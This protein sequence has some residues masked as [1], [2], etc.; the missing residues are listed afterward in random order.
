[1][2]IYELLTNEIRAVPT[3]TF[4]QA[5]VLE[6]QHLQRVLKDKIDIVAPGVMVLTEE[7]SEWQD[8]KRRIDLLALDSQAN[9]VVI[10][11]KRDED[12]GHMDLQALRYASMVST[13]TFARAVDIHQRYL[14]KH[15]RTENAREAILNHL[16]W[17]NPLEEEFAKDVCIVLV[18]AD[19]SIE[20]TSTVMWLNA[21]DI[22]IRCVRVQP[23]RFEDRIL[24]DVQQIIPLPE[25]ASY[26]IQL[27]DKAAE[28][29]TSSR[30]A[31]ESPDFT[32]Y[33]LSID[34]IVHRAQ[35]KRRMAYL[36]VRAALARGATRESLSVPDRKWTV[37]SGN[38]TTREEF[39]KQL[40]ATHGPDAHFNEERW[41][42]DDGELLH[43][44]TC[45]FALSNQWS[46]ADVLPLIDHIAEEYPELRISYTK[47]NS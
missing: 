43:D 46:R 21:R 40:R 39:L 3:T 4:A 30:D 24:L 33:D 42:L 8:S 29:R 13:M 6:R 20:I 28:V 9:L 32:R 18:S 1:M 27:R 34:G 16:Q 19:F 12:G 25:A 45:T 22:D 44:A 10:E 41:F 38:V 37:V 26:Q 15:R 5:Q 11:L 23:Y 36:T 47:T 14:N 2:A 31:G 35:W 17:D 7:F